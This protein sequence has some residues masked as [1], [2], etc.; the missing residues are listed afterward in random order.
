MGLLLKLGF[1]TGTRG[2]SINT[3]GYIIVVT[4]AMAL[5]ITF[6][7]IWR[8]KKRQEKEA[9]ITAKV[10]YNDLVQEHIKALWKR[11]YNYA[12]M[13][14]VERGT[15]RRASVNMSPGIMR[16]I[17]RREGDISTAEP[18]DVASETSPRSSQ[19][20]S[21]RRFFKSKKTVHV[22]GN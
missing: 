2:I 12:V 18:E 19:N 8:E 9:R 20:S 10:L 22:S 13:E 15:L 7:T 3:V 6:I 14:S 5:G 11:G 17:R 16:E 21:K 1:G 4:N